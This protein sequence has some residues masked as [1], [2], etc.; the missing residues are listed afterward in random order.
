MK[1]HRHARARDRKS[2]LSP[3]AERLVAAALGLANSGS[4]LEDRFWDAQLAT[5]LDRLLEG[6]HA[7][8]VYDAL[9]RLNQTDG[10]AYGALIEAVEEAAETI[11]VDIDGEPW[12]V[13]LVAA[14]LVVWTRF[15]IPSG[16]ISAEQ[17]QAL[18][19][20]WQAHTLARNTR[21]RMI[22]YLYSLDQLPRD[23]SELRR[24]ARRL[25]QSIVSGQAPKLDLKALPDAADM[26]ADTRFVLGAVAAPTGRPL[27]RWQETD[28]GDHANRVSCLEQW[29]AQARPNLEPL[30]PGCGF[31]CLLPDAYHINIRES[32]RRVRPYSIRAA[33]HFLTH[34]LD[35]EP[36]EI[37]AT[38]AAFGHERADEYRI[39]MSVRDDDDVVHGI[40]WPLLGAES[41]QDEPPPIEQMREV[42]REVGVGE[43]RLW[44]ELSEPEYCEDCGAPLYPNGKGEVVHAELPGDVEPES[45]HFH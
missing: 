7:Q 43:M 28:T 2:H 29:I 15:R 22:P 9:D 8:G 44:P 23:Y 42:L 14:P 11:S 26:L 12:D 20:H 41:D 25:G 33:V 24:L 4:R 13:L 17:A 30:L 10:E 1:E 16:P 5:R 35:I 45:T 39:G 3:D 31:E 40:V 27:F 36:G 19:A 38:I 37:K 18:S 21:F 34:A 32:D 6:S